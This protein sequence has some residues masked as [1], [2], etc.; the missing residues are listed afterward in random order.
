MVPPERRLGPTL[1]LIDEGKYF[2]LT[3]GR[4]TGK[5]TSLRWLVRHYREKGAIAAVWVDLQ[6]AREQ[7]DP[8]KA[9]RVLLEEMG[10]ATARDLPDLP[11]PSAAQVAE[12]LATPATAVRN[13]LVF[14]AAASPR[15]LVVLFDEADG[16]VGA[17]MVGFLSQLRAGYVA[18]SE[19]PFPHSVALVGMRQVRDY[20]IAEEDRRAVAWLGTTSPFNITADALTLPTFTRVDVEDLLAQHTA[21]TGQLFEPE[22][23]ALVFELSQGHPWFVNALAAHHRGEA[24]ARYAD[25]S[26]G[27]RAGVELPRFDGLDRRLAGLLRPPQLEGVARSPVEQ[28]RRA[29]GEEDPPR[30][31]LTRPPAS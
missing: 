25:R 7:P 30:G 2:T 4:Q 10:R 28:G 23:A 17:A 11:R 3:A 9:A 13:V 14:L 27:D 8:E 20:A 24:A 22:A 21:A 16:M 6:L 5:T 19:L 18:R 1:E 29:R 12:W 31:L 15:P 26:A